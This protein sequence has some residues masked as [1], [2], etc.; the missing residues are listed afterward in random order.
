[1][2]KDKLYHLKINLDLLAELIID[3]KFAEKRTITD[4]GNVSFYWDESS[5]IKL[6]KKVDDEYC[7]VSYNGIRIAW[8]RERGLTEIEVGDFRKW[9]TDLLKWVEDAMFEAS[10]GIGQLAEDKHQEVEEARST[11]N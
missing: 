1:M 4:I 2:D 6:S 3:S 8:Y 10:E 5:F 7:S 9:G 11:G